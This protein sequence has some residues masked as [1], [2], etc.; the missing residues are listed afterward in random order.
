M[1]YTVILT[2]CLIRLI[3]YNWGQNQR[4]IYNLLDS[5]IYF[6][7]TILTK[8]EHVSE[9]LCYILIKLTYTYVY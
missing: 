5:K 6:I 4:S 1:L 3:N 2:K 8:Q 9:K 7:L